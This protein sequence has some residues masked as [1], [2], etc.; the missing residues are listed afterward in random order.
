MWILNIFTQYW[1]GL[2]QI[3]NF[4]FFIFRQ[5]LKL[6]PIIIIKRARVCETCL[7]HGMI[8]C[9]EC[10]CILYIKQ[11]LS[12]EKCPLGLWDLALDLEQQENISIHECVK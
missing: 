11:R 2:I 7:F 5:D 12:N 6:S 3:I 4:V 1:H 9:Q 10:G 8:F